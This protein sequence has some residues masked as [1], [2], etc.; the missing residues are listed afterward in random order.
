MEYVE[1]EHSVIFSYDNVQIACYLKC[2]GSFHIGGKLHISSYTYCGLFCGTILDATRINSDGYRWVA[3]LHK[4][5]AAGNYVIKGK[6][7][8]KC[9][10]L[11]NLLEYLW[12]RSL[13]NIYDG[14]IVKSESVFRG[15]DI[16]FISNNKIKIYGRTYNV[17]N[18][19]MVRALAD[20]SWGV[21]ASLIN[22]EH[23]IWRSAFPPK[24]KSARN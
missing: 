17:S 8:A 18:N 11:Y 19:F 22:E 4:L 12:E 24:A 3:N 13:S 10:D 7:L 23:E 2:D 14:E 5:I 16:E 1:G 9:L 6:L 20:R 21:Y 15:T